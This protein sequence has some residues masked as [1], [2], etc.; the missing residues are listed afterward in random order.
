MTVLVKAHVLGG[1]EP[2]IKSDWGRWV[3]IL[4]WKMLNK[5]HA[6]RTASAS[7]FTVLLYMNLIRFMSISIDS[8][9][10]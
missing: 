2:R 4:L 6:G 9:G 10:Y 5:S 1:L 3:M 7:I 8:V